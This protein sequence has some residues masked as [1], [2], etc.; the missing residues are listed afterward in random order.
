MLRAFEIDHRERLKLK[1]VVIEAQN[2][3]RM[4][5]HLGEPLKPPPRAHA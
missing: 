5:R 2:I 4:L 1:A 3:E